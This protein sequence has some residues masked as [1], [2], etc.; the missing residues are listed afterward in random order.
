MSNKI[1]VK[2]MLSPAKIDVGKGII[3]G[4]S[5]ITSGTAKGHGVQVD[6]MTLEQV[7]ACAETYARG[8]K[9]KMTHQGDAGDIVGFLTDFRIAGCKLLA[10]LTLLKTSRFRDY[11][12]EVAETIPD[13]IGLS[14]AFSGPTETIGELR[15]ARCTEIYSADL[16]S[17][18]AANPTGLFSTRKT[19]GARFE[20]LVADCIAS[21]LSDAGA[22]RYCV[23]RYGEA[24]RDYLARVAHGEVITLGASH[25]SDIDKQT[26]E[27]LVREGVKNRRTLADSINYVVQTYPD[28]HAAYLK[29]VQ[30]GEIIKL[31]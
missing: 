5:V 1:T 11:V 9:V 13:T 6:A 18:P 15:F 29:R 8:L 16:V 3:Y 19:A 31:S 24:Y 2:A 17:E 4:V 26:F 25:R 27:S 20:T 7:K 28:K 30:A 12:L 21:G 22:I 14:I 23:K 10:D